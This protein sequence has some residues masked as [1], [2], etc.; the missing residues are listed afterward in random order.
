M[1]PEQSPDVRINEVI[2]EINVTEG[3]GPLSALEVKRIVALVLEQVQ[4]EQ[5]R[6]EERAR[7]TRIHDRAFRPDARG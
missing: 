5:H 3:V 7:D 2:T 4:R 1:P 6:L